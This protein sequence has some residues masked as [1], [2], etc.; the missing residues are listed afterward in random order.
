[1]RPHGGWVSLPMLDLVA[2]TPEALRR[3]AAAI[4]AAQREA[5]PVLVC[6]ALGYGR[7]VAALLVWLV[8]TGGRR[9]SPP[10]SRSCKPSAHGWCSMKPSAMLCN[11]P[12]R[13]GPFMADEPMSHA[14]PP[15]PE[16]L[17][18]A[19][20]LR[21]GRLIHGLALVLLLATGG[22]AAGLA[23]DGRLAGL[24]AWLL[25]IA[26]L[27]GL[28]ETWFAFRVG[29]DEQLF[30]ALGAGQLTLPTLDSGLAGLGLVPP[31]KAGGRLRPGFRGQSPAG[32]A[33]RA[34]RLQLVLIMAALLILA[35]RVSS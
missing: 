35:A 28:A 25:A 7:S 30:A 2:P 23:L 27:A 34:C 26:M 29:L 3:A 33:G 24:P 16:A 21:Q 15:L 8:L 32:Q 18:M 1:M 12:W 9:I 19:A 10:R 22:L 20:L 5:R 13:K 17:V 31:G 14:P 4:E 6:C 11:R